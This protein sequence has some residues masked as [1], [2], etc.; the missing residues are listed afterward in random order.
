M[1]GLYTGVADRGGVVV[2]VLQWVHRRIDF[3]AHTLGEYAS[4]SVM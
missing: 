3:V 2:C 4:Q 1:V